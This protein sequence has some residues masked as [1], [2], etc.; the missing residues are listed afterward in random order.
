M[1]GRAPSPPST[2]NGTYAVRTPRHIDAVSDA[3]STAFSVGDLPQDWQAMLRQLD[4][5]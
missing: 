4:R 5:H 3:L 1:T 2:T